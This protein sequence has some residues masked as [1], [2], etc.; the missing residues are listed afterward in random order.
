MKTHKPLPGVTVGDI[1]PKAYR[2][3]G[4]IDN[5]YLRVDNV[6][7]P[8]DNL[9]QRFCKVEKNGVY[10]PPVHDKLSYGS[11]VYL[12]AGIPEVAGWE[13]ARAVTTATRYC[14][15]RR[16][17]SG[18]GGSSEDQVIKYASVKFRLTPMLARAYAF[19]LAGRQFWKLY[20]TMADA[21]VNRHDASLLPEVHNL[22][23][24]LKVVSTWDGTSGAEEVRKAMGGH[25]FSVMGGVSEIVAH[26][27]PAQTYE[28]D[29]FVISQQISRALLKALAKIAKNPAEVSKLSSSTTYLQLLLNQKAFNSARAAAASPADWINQ[30]VQIAALE[31]RAAGLVGSLAAKMQKNPG[32]PITDLSWDTAGVARAHA[33]VYFAREFWNSI[34]ALPASK[35]KDA[36]A[37]LAHIFALDLLVRNAADLF[38]YGHVDARQNVALKAAYDGLVEG[39]ST[40]MAIAMTDAFGF[41]D[42]EMGILGR[43]DGAFYQGMWDEVRK[44]N[45]KLLPLREEVLRITGVWKEKARL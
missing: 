22:S 9:L 15:V 12:R 19:I 1:G 37:T 29:N 17:F 42:Y 6:R 20:E 8:R 34:N 13:L 5:G 26:S 36:L 35:E 40:E 25:G 30:T 23:T 3:F 28:G 32:K 18:T 2:G 16:Q 24:A 45:E 43:E 41:D 33:E 38:Q 27:T 10:T 31:H 14:T 4:S 39:F 7:I 11:M 21:L 44:N